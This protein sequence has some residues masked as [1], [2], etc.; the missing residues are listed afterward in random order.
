MT[1]LWFLCVFLFGGVNRRTLE[2]SSR[3]QQNSMYLFGGVGVGNHRDRFLKEAPSSSSAS[4][5][6]YPHLLLDLGRRPSHPAE[7]KE[8]CA[9][10]PQLRPW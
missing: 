8:G 2:R 1:G 10:N 3:G 9:G 6:V 7:N 5:N 4:L